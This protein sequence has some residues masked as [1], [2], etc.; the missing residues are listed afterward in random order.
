MLEAYRTHKLLDALESRVENEAG[1]VMTDVQKLLDEQ[2]SNDRAQF[3]LGRCQV[4]LD[5]P[6]TAKKTFE[7]LVDHAPGN[8]QA[9]VELAKIHH[10][11]D[12]IAAAIGLL[13][14]ATKE[15]PEVAETWRLLARYLRQ[16]GQDQAGEEARRQ[17]DMIRAFNSDLQ[18]AETACANAD[19]RAADQKCR[20]LLQKVPGEIRTLRI[21]ARIAW[22][23]RY[24]EAGREILERCLESRP[25]DPSLR[26]DYARALLAGKKYRE[27]LVQC[28]HV[29]DLAPETIDIYEV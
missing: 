24:Y 6:D 21:L 3:I 13:Q 23:M 16:D 22:Q 11:Q 10:G 20:N 27:A 12:D 28:D 1:D 19:L 4:L 5:E 2:P 9:K 14:Q 7:T 15:A 18:A 29:T 17:F 26:L 8:V 25:D